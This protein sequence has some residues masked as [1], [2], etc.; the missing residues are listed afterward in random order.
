MAQ[1]IVSK[2]IESVTLSDIQHVLITRKEGNKINI[3]VAY[4]VR[5]DSGDIFSSGI[6]E[7]TIPASRLTD[8]VNFIRNDI[9]PD[10]N[11]KLGF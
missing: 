2:T 1:R 11:T 4:Q 9:L 8:L 3:Q 7:V 6:K 10:L 5:E